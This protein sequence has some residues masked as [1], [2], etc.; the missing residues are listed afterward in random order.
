MNEMSRSS[1]VSTKDRAAQSKRPKPPKQRRDD[2]ESFDRRSQYTPFFPQPQVPTWVSQPQYPTM[3]TQPFNGAVQSNYGTAV[4]P[5]FSQPSQQ[6][7]PNMM[8]NGNMQQ[9]NNM[10]QVNDGNPLRVILTDNGAAVSPAVSTAVSTPQCAYHYLWYSSSIAAGSS[11]T[12]AT[13]AA[14]ALPEPIPVSATNPCQRTFEL[15]SIC[16]W[17]IA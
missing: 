5:Q 1:S 8:N 7:N 6:Y 12:V 16:L 4:P 13:T 9:Y 15:N 11:P 17:P 3:P 10:A 14:A 2:S